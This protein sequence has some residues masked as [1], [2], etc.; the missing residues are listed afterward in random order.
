M[1]MRMSVDQGEPL[2]FVCQ[3]PLKMVIEQI[4]YEMVVRKILDNQAIFN[5]AINDVELSN[6]ELKDLIREVYE[7]S[8][9]SISIVKG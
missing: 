8:R 3:N 5:V 7:M 6:T 4:P 9:N 1:T 2:G